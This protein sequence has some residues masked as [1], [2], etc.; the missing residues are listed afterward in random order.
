MTGDNDCNGDHSAAPAGKFDPQEARRMLGLTDKQ[1]AFAQ[2][3]LRGMNQT[4]AAREAGYGG[5]D[6]QLRTAGNKAARSS[7]VISFLAWAEREG[8]GVSDDP[9]NSDELKKILSRHARSADK[10]TAI[11]AMEVLH[12]IN[13]AEADRDDANAHNPEETLKDIAKIDI[14]LADRMAREFNVPL[15]LTDDDRQRLAAAK[16]K[17]FLKLGAE[18]GASMA[19]GGAMRGTE[20]TQQAAV[21]AINGTATPSPENANGALKGIEA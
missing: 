2:A 11:R 13:Q 21:A 8:A 1:F 15:A 7:A 9:C 5:S 4:Q 19:N 14:V 3:R 12:R 20:A 16:Q 6:A 17:F 10:N 18:L